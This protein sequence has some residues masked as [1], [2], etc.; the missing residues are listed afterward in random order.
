MSALTST[1]PR[2]RR[3]AGQNALLLASVTLVVASFLPWVD[4]AF[5]AFSGMAGAGVYTFYAGVWGI[6]GGLMPWRRIALAHAVVVTAAALLLPAWQIA[7][8]VSRQLDGGW[9][10]GTGIMLAIASGSLAARAVWQLARQ[11]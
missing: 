1:R 9:V 2:S 6:G 3:H 7:S 5:G 10:P 4:T 8:L 11:E